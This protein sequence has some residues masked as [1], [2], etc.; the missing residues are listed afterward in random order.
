MPHSSPLSRLAGVAATA[1]IAMMAFG[2]A[3][4][5]PS[6]PVHPVRAGTVSATGST[7]FC[8]QPVVVNGVT[9]KGYCYIRN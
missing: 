8:T 2:L 1:A 6:H 7:V 3:G 4:L 9:L 5:H